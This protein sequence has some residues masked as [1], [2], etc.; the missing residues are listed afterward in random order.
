MT[1]IR[2]GRGVRI[3][4][5]AALIA[6]ATSEKAAA[7]QDEIGASA[8]AA[9]IERHPTVE[10]DTFRDFSKLVRHDTRHASL[11]R[12]LENFMSGGV[13]DETSWVNVSRLLG[14]YVRLRHRD[15]LL[16]TLSDLVAIPTDKRGDQPQHQNPEVRRFGQSIGRLA[17]ELGLD[18]R[19]VDNRIFEV[20]LAGTSSESIGVFTHGD[21]V[22]ADPTKW[23]LPTASGS[24]RSR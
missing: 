21:V 17:A 2:H 12:S 19:D 24:I 16:G 11:A 8:I 13:L 10:A 23:V 3:L 14:L 18:F 22:P 4:V 5:G 1:R 7:D 9:L 20:T 15:S 6:L